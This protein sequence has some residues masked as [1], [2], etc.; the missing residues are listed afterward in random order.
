MIPNEEYVCWYCKGHLLSLRL[1]GPFT[2]TPM[3]T[4]ITD[5]KLALNIHTAIFKED[6]QLWKRNV[7]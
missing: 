6:V 3:Q 2:D 7:Y 4:T 5:K 1:R